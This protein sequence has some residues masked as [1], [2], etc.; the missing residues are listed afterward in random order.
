MTGFGAGVLEVP[1][2]F[3]SELAVLAPRSRDRCSVWASQHRM[4]PAGDA[5]H[6]GL[7]DPSL[8]PYAVEVLDTVNDPGVEEV[9]GMFGAQTGKSTIGENIVGFLVCNE[10]CPI[11]WVMPRRPDY[12]YVHGRRIE[13]MIANS[14]TIAAR[15]TGRADDVSQEGITFDACH[16]YYANAESTGSLKSR[17]VRVVILDEV[18]EMRD[19]PQGDPT[20]IAKQRTNTYGSRRKVYRWSTPTWRHGKVFKAWEKSDQRRFWVPCHGCG[21]FQLLEWECVRWD[22][23]KDPDVARDLAR[24]VCPHC[25]IEWNDAQR[26]DSVRAGVWVPQG[27]ELDEATGKAIVPKPARH[28][29]YQLSTLYSCLTPLGDLVARFLTEDLADFTRQILALPWEEQHEAVHADELAKCIGEYAEGDVPEEAIALTAGVDVQGLKLGL[30]YV[31]RAWGPTGE[32]WLVKRGRVRTWAGIEE[33]ITDAQYGGR[34]VDL[35]FI[36]SGDGRRR[37]EVYDFC[38]QHPSKTMPSKGRDE[39]QGGA[40]LS[41]SPIEKNP[42]TGASV[43]GGLRLWLINTTLFKDQ[44]AACIA[45]EREPWH[46]PR[47]EEGSLDEYLA[48][49]RAEQKVAHGAAMRWKLKPGKQRNDYWDCEVMARAAWYLQ[50]G[51][52][53]RSKGKDGKRRARVDRPRQAG[54]TGSASE[55]YVSRADARRTSVADGR[56][57]G[58]RD[59]GSGGGGWLGG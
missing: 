9:T 48:H 44:L 37:D 38:R 7:W 3:P 15:L 30:F 59:R 2:W 53:G 8:A 42:I 34:P 26:Q 14:P 12:H 45:G 25:G 36:D 11:M 5:A 32:S 43:R 10:P 27:C 23:E 13:P 58:R 17:T 49:L 46:L 41:A 20:S 33:A 1:A 50:W 39:L 28:R 24:Y 16:L 31:V 4:I 54:R 21:R 55:D 6:P 29:G 40:P 22:G 56:R 35:A 47:N 52:M 51:Q 18:D 57:G 19:G